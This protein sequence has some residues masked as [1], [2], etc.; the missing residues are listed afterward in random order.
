MLCSVSTERY[1]DTCLPA[2]QQGLSMADRIVYGSL[3]PLR[4]KICPPH[5]SGKH[6]LAFTVQRL[7]VA[8]TS[9]S[10]L[11]MDWIHTRIG[12]DWIG[13]DDCDPA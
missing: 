12:L 11:D 13:W 10:E 8:Y 6:R 9:H 4:D 7:T 2:V 1:E 3:A 5:N